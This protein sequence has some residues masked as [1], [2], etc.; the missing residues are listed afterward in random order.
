MGRGYE[1]KVFRKA[2]QMCKRVLKLSHIQRSVKIEVTIIHT[3]AWEKMK[4]LMI[5]PKFV[6]KQTLTHGYK[7]L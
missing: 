2:F 6:G 7:Y 5:D 1:H 3:L 4:L